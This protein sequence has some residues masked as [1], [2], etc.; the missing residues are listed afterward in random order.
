MFLLGL[1]LVA[2][3]VGLATGFGALE[4]YAATAG[5]VHA[6]Q[7]GAEAFLAQHHR[8]ARGLI[9]MAVHPLC[10]CTRASLAELGDLLARSGGTCDALIVEYHPGT[11]PADWT[12][13]GPSMDLG[14]VRVPVLQDRDG[15]IARELGAETSGHLVFVDPRGDVRFQ[16]GLTLARGHR[17]RAPAQDAILALLAGGQPAVTRAPVF[18]CT[19]GPECEAG[20]TP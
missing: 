2:W 4:R 10:P 13:S 16:G 11:P 8:P 12:S 14:G 1:A 17:G 7:A 20:P 3:V 19:L 9:V 18:G 6:P 5:R 15:T